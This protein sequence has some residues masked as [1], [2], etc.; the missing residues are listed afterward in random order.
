MKALLSLLMSVA[1][2]ACGVSDAEPPVADESEIRGATN[3]DVSGL[4]C[5]FDTSSGGSFTVVGA[6]GGRIS[7]DVY[8][9]SQ[10]VMRRTP[11]LDYAVTSLEVGRDRIAIVAKAAGRDVRTDE[12][13]YD[14]TRIEIRIDLRDPIF[15]SG[16]FR[17]GGS[18]FNAMGFDCSTSDL[19]RIRR[20]QP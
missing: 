13:G 11:R 17:V 15:T 9:E 12:A 4:R 10:L 5:T 7:S 1:F 18:S 19:E 6:P 20:V 8:R 14:F 3:F 16:A 2:V